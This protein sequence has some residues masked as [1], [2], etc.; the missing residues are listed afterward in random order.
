M[1]GVGRG[2]IDSSSHRSPCNIVRHCS[3]GVK[4]VSDQK[5]CHSENLG[6]TS[7]FATL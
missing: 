6:I 3:I 7:K 4:D 2:V 1:A 5:L